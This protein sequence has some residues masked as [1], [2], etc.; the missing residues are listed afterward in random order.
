MCGLVQPDLKV[1]GFLPVIQQVNTNGT[2]RLKMGAVTDT[3]NIRRIV[4]YMP[5]GLWLFWKQHRSNFGQAPFWRYPLANPFV[6]F[7]QTRYSLSSID[8]VQHLTRSITNKILW[9]RYFFSLY[10]IFGSSVHPT[11][12]GQQLILLTCMLK[13][14]TGRVVAALVRV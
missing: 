9:Y 8:H 6:V 14:G 7:C 3:V 4:P 12:N 10:H 11:T 2:V 5:L 13:L 1:L